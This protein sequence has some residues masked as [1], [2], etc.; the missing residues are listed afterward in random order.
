MPKLPGDVEMASELSEHARRCYFVDC[1]R[2]DCEEAFI[3]KAEALLAKR[4]DE[5]A[6][7]QNLIWREQAYRLAE[8]AGTDISVGGYALA[9]VTRVEAMTEAPHLVGGTDA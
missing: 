1:Y 5:R 8:V 7:E 6:A 4:G 9:L 2:S 3:S